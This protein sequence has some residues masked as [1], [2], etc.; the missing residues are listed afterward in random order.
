MYDRVI[1]FDSCHGALVKNEMM[2]DPPEIQRVSNLIYGQ[3]LM[4][5]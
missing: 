4:L 1:L 3:Q 5:C 2:G